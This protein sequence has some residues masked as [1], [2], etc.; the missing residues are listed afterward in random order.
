MDFNVA[1]YGTV[2]I[3]PNVTLYL[4]ETLRNTWIII[5][6]LTLF[7]IFVRI[8]LNSFTEVPRGF[9][10]FIELAID[11]FNNFVR[12]TAGKE[13]TYLGGW[14]FAVFMFVAVSNIIG[15][16]PGMRPPTADWTATLPLAVV[17]FLMIQGLAF[18]YHPKDHAK[19]F[20]EPIFIFFPL[21]VLGEIA[22]IVSLSFRL[23][24]NVLGGM[25]LLTLIYAMTPALVQFI[26]PVVLHAYFDFA[27]GL[28]QAYVFVV[29][30]LAFISAAANAGEPSEA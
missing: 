13:L 7:A 2:E 28:L 21:N 19:G 16:V 5:G 23:F 24:G 12:G 20:F 6:L 9:Q 30:S 1:V 17:S 15:L 25:I 26:V 29:L 11:A 22:K 14:F 8:K 18:Y 3:L 10:N 4:T 27:S